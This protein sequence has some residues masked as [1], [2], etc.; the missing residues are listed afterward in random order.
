ME[1]YYNKKIRSKDEKS[2]IKNILIKFVYILILPVIIWNLAIVVQKIQNPEKTPSVFGIK[3]FCIIS[4]SMEPSIEVNDMVII[5]EVAQ[6]EIQIGD[7]ISFNKNGEIITHRVTYIEHSATGQLLYITRGDANNI[8]DKDKIKYENIEG[9]CIA[10][11]PKVGKI[12]L[13]L[14]N[15]GTLAIVLFILI[16]IYIIMQK[17]DYKKIRRSNERKKYEEKLEKQKNEPLD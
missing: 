7:I 14:T 9:K 3:M 17:N 2:L 10:R 11:I 16:L 15:K 5:K 1:E 4:G 12:V 13:I 8:E 6:G